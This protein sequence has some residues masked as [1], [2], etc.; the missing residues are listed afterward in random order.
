MR[1]AASLTRRMMNVAEEACS[2][3]RSS[4]LSFVLTLRRPLRGG[5]LQVCTCWK[6]S[7]L[8]LT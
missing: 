1:V 5:G 6:V 2:W 4:P 3:S 7:M 8:L